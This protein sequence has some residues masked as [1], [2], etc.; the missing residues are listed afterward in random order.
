MELSS[1]AESK[2]E[3]QFCGQHKAT[4]EAGLAADCSNDLL[5]VRRIERRIPLSPFRSYD[6]DYLKDSIKATSG[7]A[8]S[9]RVEV[10]RSAFY[11]TKYFTA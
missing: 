10:N 3:S 9:Y 5:G 4:V 6:L 1:R 8:S 2:R 7:L 11:F